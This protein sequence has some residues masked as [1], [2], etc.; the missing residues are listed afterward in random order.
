V[1]DLASG[2]QT[3]RKKSG[4][5]R[6]SPTTSNDLENA[7]LQVKRHLRLWPAMPTTTENPGIRSRAVFVPAS[8]PESRA[9]TWLLGELSG[10]HSASSM[11]RQSTVTLET[12]AMRM[13]ASRPGVTLEFS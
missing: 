7:F 12:W 13:T 5:G 9:S 1:P 10:R 6:F 2:P 8:T 4:G 11:S 3:V